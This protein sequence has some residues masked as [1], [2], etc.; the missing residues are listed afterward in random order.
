MG[1]HELFI[2]LFLYHENI[3]RP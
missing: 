3:M 2:P 1:K